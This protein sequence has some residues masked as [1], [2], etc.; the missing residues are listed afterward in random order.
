MLGSLERAKKV[1]GQGRAYGGQGQR[2]CLFGKLKL[3]KW[4]QQRQL[5][6]KTHMGHVC[7]FFSTEILLKS[8]CFLVTF[9]FQVVLYQKG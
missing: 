6:Q 2:D 3:G 7:L 4:G 1:N 8:N 9:S 5:R